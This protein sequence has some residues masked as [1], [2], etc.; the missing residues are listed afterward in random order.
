MSSSTLAARLPTQEERAAVEK[1]GLKAMEAIL[2]QVMTEDAFYERLQEAFN[3]ILLTYGYDGSG[4]DALSY[5]HFKSRH[6]Y[7]DRSPN[8]D[9]S[10]ETR[11]KYSHPK[12]IAYTKLVSD[13]REGMRR[14]PLE[15]V[16]YIV[17]NNRPFT[18][19]V[20]AA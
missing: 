13:Y 20:T 4:E 10:P 11:L 16:T 2:D 7:Q 18:E 14:E 6:W 8:K 3:D 15:L 9:R 19:I 5:E 12:M 1:N 17:S